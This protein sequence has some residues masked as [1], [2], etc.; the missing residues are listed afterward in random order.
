MQVEQAPEVKL[1]PS[2]Q[3]VHAVGL[4]QIIQLSEHF[5]HTLLLDKTYP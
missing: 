3:V 5:K 1:N 4:L 2:L